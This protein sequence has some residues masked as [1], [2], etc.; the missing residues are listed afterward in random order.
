M[1]ILWIRK[2]QLPDALTAQFVEHGTNLS[3][4]W[5][6]SG[7]N[8]TTTWVVYINAMINHIF[9]SFYAVQLYDISYIHL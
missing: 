7:L 3:R 9:I 5:S 1:G 4:V 8:F 2:D 6:F